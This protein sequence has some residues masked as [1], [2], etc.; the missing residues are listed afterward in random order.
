MNKSRCKLII[1]TAVGAAL[2]AN[3]ASAQTTS[4][5]SIN[6]FITAQ[7]ANEW[8]ARVFIGAKVRNA[9]GDMVG[10]I[11]D[12]I[13]DRSGRISTVVLGVG[14]FLGVGEKSVAVAYSALTVSVDKD[15]KRLITVAFSSEALKLAPNF[16]ATEKTT[17]EAVEDKAIE[18]GKKTSEKAGQIK[19]QAL[20]K[21]EEMQQDAPKKP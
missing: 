10:D 13:F 8:M 7:P 19:D 18:L 20:K 6:Q 3:P 5:A 14:G 17:L 4:P 9:T 21:I 1:G 2:L 11:N 12:L 15:G 16:V